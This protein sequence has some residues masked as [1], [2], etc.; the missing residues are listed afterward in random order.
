MS[1]APPGPLTRLKNPWPAFSP[2]QP[3]SSSPPMRGPT[4]NRRCSSGFVVRSTKFF[5]T[6]VATSRPVMSIVLKV[7]LFGRPM[8]GPV[9]ASIVSMSNGPCSQACNTLNRP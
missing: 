9:S 6:W 5:A 8:A 1:E 4:V 7:A 2:I 3:R